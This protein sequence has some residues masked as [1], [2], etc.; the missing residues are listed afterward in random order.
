MRVFAIALVASLLALGASGQTDT[1]PTTTTTT[2]TTTTPTANADARQPML[3]SAYIGM[4][5]DNFAG[6]EV[7]QYLNPDDA[8]DA[9][10]EFI[11]GVNFE[12]RLVGSP[13]DRQQLW[14]YGETVHGARSRDVDCKSGNNA[15]LD[16]CDDHIPGDGTVPTGGTDEFIA[17][18]RAASSLEAFLGLRYEFPPPLQSGTASPARLYVKGQLGF[19]SVTGGG[20]DAVD[21]HHVAIGAITVAGPFEGSHLEIG[22]GRNDLFHRNPNERLV[23]DAILSLSSDVVPGTFSAKM[24]PFIQFTG[25]FD[26]GSGSDSIQTWIGID[27]RFMQ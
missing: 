13:G 20:G 4:V 2:T 17:I 7:L 3:A 14:I 23:V 11:A 26:G 15:Q 9:E 22:Y 1:T 19:L 21:D 24:R 10:W 12:Y 6:D 16:I 5:I 27:Y 18:L 8:N 25:S